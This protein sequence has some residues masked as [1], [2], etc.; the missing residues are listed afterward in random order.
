ML[1][2]FHE[3]QLAAL[4]PAR[5]A[6]KVLN[7]SVSVPWLPSNYSRLARTVTAGTDLFERLTRPYGK[8]AFG[9]SSTVING[10]TVGVTE[11]LVL[12]K[13][14]CN[15][16]HF[17]R[18]AAGRNDPKLLIVA[19]ISGHYAT[20]LR[21]TVE[22]LLPDHDV[23]IT[24]WVNARNVPVDQGKFDLSDNV[25]YIIEFI[26]T[27]GGNTSIVAVCQP[28]VPVL[29]AAS[30]MAQNNDPLRPPAIVLMGGPIDTRRNPTM[31]NQ[32]AAQHPLEW[33]ERS[34]IQ[35]VPAN[36]PGH[37]RRVYPGFLQLSGFISMN[38]QRHQ[39]AFSDYF[40]NVRDGNSEATQQHLSFYDEYLSVLDLTAEF[41][42]ET[43]AEVFQKHSLPTGTMVIDGQ[44][45][46]LGAITDIGLLTIEGGRDDITGAGQT[47]AAHDLCRNLPAELRQ[48]HFEETAG[49]YGI[50][51]GRHWRNAI[52][53]V[54][55]AFVRE[56]RLRVGI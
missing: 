2:L 54:V 51:S 15:L 39:E 48:H 53:P 7:T 45:V 26:H 22:T 13:P 3:M 32:F 5:L 55:K 25:N 20:L 24:D 4:A 14:F 46:D 38:K 31:V 37:G 43:V 17:R 21:A 35:S 28:S 36:F 49:H 8:P 1:Y 42:L 30:L 41:Y 11:E 12:A 56:H 52:A 50:F 34:L 47:M 40:Q 6:A 23:Y 18:A 19:P 16:V 29:I 44:L 33:F 10:E 27:L 9:L